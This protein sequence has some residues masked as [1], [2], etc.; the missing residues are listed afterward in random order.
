MSIEIND[1]LIKQWEPKIQK[2]LTTTYVYG[3]DK[4][5]LEQELRIAIVKAAN[6]FNEDRGVIFHTYLH[7]AMVNVL[8]TL[9][10]KAQKRIITES[11]DEVNAETE[12]LP[13]K[14][15]QALADKTNLEE[16]VGF[17]SLVEG[18][19]FTAL[20]IR[21]IK[22]R[23]EGLTM[24]EISKQI[25]DSAYRIRQKLQHKFKGVLN[26]ENTKET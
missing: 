3:W 12:M 6:G 23:L 11:L 18:T 8:R 2:L 26:E 15:M 20:E 10:A 5:D 25:G 17:T 19:E 21:F 9:M 4:E 1:D 24:L 22:L 14:I 16:E 13:L 7:T